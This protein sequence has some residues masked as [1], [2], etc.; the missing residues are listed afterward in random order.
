[1]IDGLHTLI[2]AT[3]AS[4]QRGGAG[5]GTALKLAKAG[6]LP[7]AVRVGRV[8]RVRPESFEDAVA[9]LMATGPAAI[10]PRLAGAS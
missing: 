6:K 5:Y 1:M 8:W 2:E 4:Q 7:G 10:T 3:M 9:R